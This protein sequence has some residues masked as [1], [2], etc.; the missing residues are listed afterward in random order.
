MTLTE[1][2]DLEQGTDAWHDVRRGIVTASTVGN[3][4][5]T[6]K[7]SAIDYDCPNCGA[8]KDEPCIAKKAPHGPL[9][10]MHP[11]RAET[12]R[13]SKNGIVFETASNDIS[14][15]LTMSLVAERITDWTEPV[16]VNDDMMRGTLDE[17]LARD[18]YSEHYAPVTQTGFLLLEEPGFRLGYS[19]D[20]MVSTEGLIEV[21]SRRQKKQV[22]TVL[23]GHPPTENMPQMQAGLLVTGRDWIDYVSYS[24]GMPMWVKRVYPDRRW[25]DA[26]TNAVRAFEANAAEMVRLYRESIEGFPMTERTVLSELEIF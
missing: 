9:K 21:K 6:R 23:S 11:D 14:R 22:E 24:G 5:T 4:I 12:A 15:S 2:K 25:F 18:K 13:N 16:Y 7:L 1:Y 19:P 26:I 3:L 10:T 8:P 20:G 17:P